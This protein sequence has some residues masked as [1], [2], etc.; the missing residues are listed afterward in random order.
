MKYWGLFICSHITA[1]FLNIHFWG[2][3][4]IKNIVDEGIIYFI[5]ALFIISIIMI[6]YDSKKYKIY[7]K[8]SK[9]ELIEKLQ[10]EE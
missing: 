8:L 9:G 7:T 4:S 10:E 3:Q 6:W 1:F 5:I 2:K